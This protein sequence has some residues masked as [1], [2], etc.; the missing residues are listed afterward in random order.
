MIPLTEMLRIFLLLPILGLAAFGQGGLPD[1]VFQKIP[2]DEWLKG[3]GDARIQWSMQLSPVNLAENQRLETYFWAVIGADEL[4]KRSKP[5]QVVVFLEIRDHAN[6]VYRTHRALAVAK[7]QNQAEL[8]A[9]KFIQ[10]MYVMPGDYQV[11]VAVYDTQ[12]KEHSLKKMR[13]RVP[14]LAHDP[15]RGAWRDLPSV[16]FSGRSSSRL[17]LPLPTEKPVRIEVVVNEAPKG[18][19]GKLLSALRI[20][21]QMD[22]MNGS[23]KVELLDLERRRISFAQEVVDDLDWRGL[24]AALRQNDPNKIDVHALQ[25]YKE[26]A[27]FFVSEIRKRLESGESAGAT[28]V[29]I[30][31]SAPMA[32]PK[33]EDLQPIEATPEPGSRVFYIRCELA[34]PFPAMPP[35]QLPSPGSWPV[36]PERPYGPVPFQR[37]SNADSLERTLRP[38]DPRLFN[39]STPMQFRSALAAILSEIA[40]LK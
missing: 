29:L 27:Q 11:A 17:Y 15:L 7:G 16:D 4:V 21:S 36:P 5:G 40:E 26:N 8:A 37:A 38:L 20:I 23:M 1:P 33:G 35:P 12:S 18:Y 39:V 2:F 25:N 6:R 14:E 10:R 22:I 32:F 9:V 31:L 34:L 30:V 24:N 13:L 28:R 19:A 3:G